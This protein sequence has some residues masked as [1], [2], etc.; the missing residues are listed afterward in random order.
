MVYCREGDEV[1]YHR[2][3]DETLDELTEFLEDLGERGITHKDFDTS[4]AVCQHTQWP[5]MLTSVARDAGHCHQNPL[6]QLVQTEGV[7]NLF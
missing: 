6:G 7:L 5:C 2:V 4:L 3:A 1:T